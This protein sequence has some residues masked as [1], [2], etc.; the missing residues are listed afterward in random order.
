MEETVRYIAAF[1]YKKKAPQDI[2]MLEGDIMQVKNPTKMACFKGTLEEPTGWL[3]GV[4]MRTQER[5]IFPGTF[6][7]Y[8]V[9]PQEVPPV[10]RDSADSTTRLS[11]TSKYPF[12][13]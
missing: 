13:I 2:E 4:N 7:K 11:I 5:G 9:M 10:M 3:E 1:P 8:F 12:Y 6:V